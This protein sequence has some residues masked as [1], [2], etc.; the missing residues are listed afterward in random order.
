MKMQNA[1]NKM[2][3]IFKDKKAI[4]DISI[5]AVISFIFLATA[6]MIPFINSEFGTTASTFDIDNL[7][8]DVKE[9]ATS[10]SRLSGFGVLKTVIQLAVFDFGNSLGLPFWL[11]LLYTG[12]GIIFILVIARNIWIGG[13]G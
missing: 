10:I 4:N 5:I 13:G 3:K 7:E 1:K 11:D 2:F 6:V 12:L 9:D 8:S